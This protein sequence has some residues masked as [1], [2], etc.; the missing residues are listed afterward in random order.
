MNNRLRTDESVIE[1][2]ID[3]GNGV[4]PASDDYQVRNVE[5]TLN[6]PSHPALMTMVSQFLQEVGETTT[7]LAM[8][9]CGIELDGDSM[10]LVEHARAGTQG[11]FLPAREWM[12]AL[13]SLAQTSKTIDELS[14]DEWMNFLGD[15][16]PLSDLAKLV[17]K[18]RDLEGNGFTKDEFLVE[19]KSAALKIN[20]KHYKTDPTVVAEILTADSPE[21]VI[22]ALTKRVERR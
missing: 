17:A 16:H 12:S 14:S 5:L 15:E 19:V 1:S 2:T 6:L 8:I 11:K 9:D 10:D 4:G 3:G 13:L 18:A 21:D 22:V 7:R 20:Q